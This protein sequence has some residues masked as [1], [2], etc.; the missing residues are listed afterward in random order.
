M[1][2][3]LEL[4]RFDKHPATTWEKK[5]PQGKNIPLFASK[6]LKIAL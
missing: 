5:I 3:E 4:G 2:G 1:V 6:L